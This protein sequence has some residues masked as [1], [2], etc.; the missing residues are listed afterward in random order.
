[1]PHPYC[2]SRSRFETTSLVDSRIGTAKPTRTRGLRNGPNWHPPCIQQDGEACSRLLTPQLYELAVETSGLQHRPRAPTNF[3]IQTTLSKRRGR[4][5]VSSDQRRHFSND[6]E[7][8]ASVPSNYRTP[9]PLVRRV[10]QPTT[11]EAS[12][13]TSGTPLC[14][15]FPSVVSDHASLE[16]WL[17]GPG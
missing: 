15:I 16:E 12:S 11:R 9:S 13:R 1:V 7:R 17:Q 2:S 8:A 3:L 14:A 10:Y 5:L 6:C 4:S